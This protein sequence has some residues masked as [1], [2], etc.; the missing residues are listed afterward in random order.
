M[1]PSVRAREDR[2]FSELPVNEGW[3]QKGPSWHGYAKVYAKV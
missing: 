1:S 3:C 2:K